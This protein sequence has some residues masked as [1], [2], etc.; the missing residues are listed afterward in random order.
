MEK[1]VTLT[2]RDQLRLKVL[3]EWD[4][5]NYT[6]A[7]AAALLG[8]CERHARR[9]LATYRQTGVA[10]IPHGNRG[11]PPAHKLTPEREQ[12]ATLLLTGEYAHFN[13]QHAQEMLAECHALCLS[14]S[15]VR[16]VR[17]AAGFKSPRKRRP[18]K[19]RRRR[20]RKPQAGMMLQIDG[21]PHRWC[22]PDGEEF[23]LLVA[24][25]DATSEV[26]ARFEEHE[27]CLGY[28]RLI[29]SVIARKGV[30]LSLYADRHSIF[31]SPKADRLSVEEQ[32]AGVEPRTQFSRA[33]HELGIN[34]ITA[35]SPQ[36]KGRVENQN[37]TL[38][39]RLVAELRHAQITDWRAAQVFLNGF[40]KRHNRRFT[41]PGAEAEVAYRQAP[42]PEVIAGALCLKF[43]RRADNANT[44]SF[45]NR[46]LALPKSVHNHA[47]SQIEIRVDLQG[48]LSFWKRGATLG[49]G[50][51]LKGA[52][53]ATVQGL[54]ALLPETPV[55]T[56]KP[57]P[58]PA[59]ARREGTA[60][61]PAA[62]HPW[63]RNALAKQPRAR[64]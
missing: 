62:D 27:N 14:V 44:C 12:Q 45:G 38:Q 56:P 28:L 2:Q 42:P 46:Q 50:P 30:P 32:L 33:C 3:Q 54:A 59:K 5:D 13:N 57:V 48:R 64:V 36:A 21:S 24:I 4:K 15:T 10:S 7:Q 25:D 34:I 49:P 31:R 55:A 9:L 26:F 18:P 41:K 16:R 19:H 1:V 58:A 17:L 63:R 51:Q 23:C 29:K 61:T 47:K 11:R 37:H 20:E 52:S 35:H 8:R 53:L 60:V 43:T 6:A 22:G 40:L 39:D